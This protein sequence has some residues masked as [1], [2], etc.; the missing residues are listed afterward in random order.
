MEVVEGCQASN[1]V[2]LQ[3]GLRKGQKTA[4]FV[5]QQSKEEQEEEVQKLKACAKGGNRKDRNLWQIK[6]KNI[7]KVAKKKDFED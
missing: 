4:S 7:I 1:L 6:C 3:K 5:Q 2:S